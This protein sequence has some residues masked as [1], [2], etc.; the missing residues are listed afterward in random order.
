MDPDVTQ[1]LDDPDLDADER[2]RRLMPLVYNQLR[3]AARQA[4]DAERPGHTLQAT[5]L[6]HEA[7]LKLVGDRQ[8]PWQ[9][10]AHFYVAAAEAIRQILIDHAR[11]RGTIKRGGR[12]RR[13]P[14][15]LSNI[16][17]L[18]QS[19][20]DTLLSVEE[21]FS[22]LEAQDERAASVCRLRL[23]AGQSSEEVARLLEVSTRT[24]E[25]EWV[26]AR[27]WLARQ[28]LGDDGPDGRAAGQDDSR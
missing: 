16:L 4:L 5:A 27:S 25:R 12:A 20:P 3:G 18:A 15:D 11:A 6:V 10:R 2:A 7:F 21:A 8:V 26:Y 14:V 19:D 28:L 22:R 17:D 23:F 1:I 24:V 13:V 9:G